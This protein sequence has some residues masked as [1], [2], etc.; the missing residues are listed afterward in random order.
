[1]R[2]ARPY[3]RRAPSW[4]RPFLCLA[5]LV[6]A[7]PAAVGQA[8]P[9]SDAKLIRRILAQ[10][11]R[12]QSGRNI[13]GKQLEMVQSPTGA[14]QIMFR[15]YTRSADGR[16]LTVVRDDNGRKVAIIEEDGQWNRSFDPRIQTLT[17]SRS[18]R[19]PT[20]ERAIEARVRRILSSYQ[21]R[22][23][24]L[25]VMA[26]RKC[27]KLTMDPHDIHGRPIKVWIDAATGV[28]L[29]RQ[30]SDRRG[31]TFGMTTF[32]S[33]SYPAKIASKDTVFTVPR[34]ARVV[35]VS[36]SPLFRDPGSLKRWA[37]VDIILPLSM[38]RGYEFEA[39]EL[40]F[41]AGTPT[42]CLR[43]SDG[44]AVITIFQ[45]QTAQAVK[46][47]Y[48]EVAWKMLPRGESVAVSGQTRVTSVVMGPRESDGVVSVARCLD[49]TRERTARA[50]LQQRF[51]IKPE[52][53]ARLRD[54]GWGVDCIAALLE[55]ARRTQRNLDTLAAMKRD[56]WSWQQIAHKFKLNPSTL[57]AGI[58]PFECH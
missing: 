7:P 48:E 21:V 6:L 58:R 5:L 12:S 19:I 46:Q 34:G 25:D 29:A 28:S 41:L 14:D 20:D 16:C 49:R 45:T 35:R 18:M 42:I 55:I 54:L 24:G 23:S 13:R 10:S 17:V 4:M 9:A 43:Y 2:F 57:A 11:I 52:K 36:R 32:T 53:L 27:H 15:T 51:A 3:P 33:V 22:Y 44:L 8:L 50:Q 37:D 40:I 1:M 39:A 30:E 26:A 47:P 31:H 56:G 38:P